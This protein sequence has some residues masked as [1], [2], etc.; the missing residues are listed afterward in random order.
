M[1]DLLVIGGGPAGVAG[2]VHAHRAGLETL[3]VDRERVGG[4]IWNAN[5]VE[6]HPGLPR[7][8]DGPAVAALLQGHLD[9]NEVPRW[10][11]EI[12]TLRREGG[13]FHAQAGS[14]CIAAR[15]VLLATGSRPKPLM[16]EGADEV[17]RSG[18]LH[19]EVSRLPRLSGSSTVLIVGGGDAA[20]DYALNCARQGARATI[21]VRGAAPRSLPL[22][23]ERAAAM[24][25]IE[26]LTGV[27][28]LR[29]FQDRSG[30]VGLDCRQEGEADERRFTADLLL[31][32]VGRDPDAS[33]AEGL[34]PL[35]PGCYDDAP[36]GSPVLYL[37][38]DAAHGR[39]R[40][41]SI[42]AGEGVLAVMHAA[43]RLC[44][45]RG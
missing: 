21:L 4:L 34:D 25:S 33:L 1:I 45:D 3:L 39:F 43:A 40:Q 18:L 28:P 5:L 27:Q 20:F 19:Y 14:D 11:T 35:R 17:Q 6:N 13:L 16:L 24:P 9:R 10:Y 32:A 23:I 31:A 37:A 30:R 44:G 8:M 2:A 36:G 12:T 41:M 22:L 26:L 15:A 38:G 7:P 29:V 42:A